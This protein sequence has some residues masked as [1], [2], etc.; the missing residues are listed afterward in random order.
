MAPHYVVMKQDSL[1]VLKLC[2]ALPFTKNG[3]A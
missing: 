1:V 3:A 2:E